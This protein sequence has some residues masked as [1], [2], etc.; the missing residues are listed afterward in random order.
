[1]QEREQYKRIFTFTSAFIILAAM[2]A[3]WAYV[4][5]E[6]YG[7]GI[8]RPFGYKGNS[9][10]IFV[11][12]FILAV[13]SKIYG[14]YRVGYYK[15]G[16]IIFSEILATV[17][18]NGI[19]YL[20]TCLVVRALMNPVPLIVMSAIEFALIFI[21]ATVTNKIYHMLYPPHNLLFVYGIR[22]SASSLIAKMTTR[23]EKYRICEA[24]SIE[25]GMETVYE[26][27]NRYS[28]VVL[29][30]IKSEY[31]NELLKYCYGKSIRVYLT[32]KIS[33]TII[34][35]AE[36]ISLFDSPLL[37]CRSQGLTA[38][39]RFFKRAFDL[40]VSSIA[41]ILTSPFMLF[42]AFL[43][44]LDKGPA[45]F[46]QERCTLDGKTFYIY[47]FRSM[48]VDAEKDGKPRPCIDD[49]PRITPVGR[50][51]R[52]TRLDELPQLFNIFLGDMSIVGPRPERVEHVEMYSREI[53]EFSFRLKVKAGLT[54]YA[55]IVG[56]YNTTAY[57][58]LK[59]DLFYIQ[60]YSFLLD[61]K[62]IL[63]TIK[64]LFMKE[65][66]EGFNPSKSKQMNEMKK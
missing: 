27:I 42:T 29:C 40:I 53:P 1:M 24:V 16:D 3:V 57:D 44:K 9:L 47:K 55:Q 12:G 8:I 39:Q 36:S 33:D 34:R 20:E 43:V 46:K 19:T 51:I 49:D 15:T 62:L 21:W 18:T 23:S 65:S 30:D 2:T 10:V 11:Y 64:V 25:D 31:R 60:N 17:F 35:G 58:K 14:A 28:S 61:I 37:L 54:G 63:M 4:W 52:K 32:P 7:E 41:I 48:V 45:I 66:T 59:L 26:K 56:R 13:F 50:F 5:F 38:E 6:Y 22:D